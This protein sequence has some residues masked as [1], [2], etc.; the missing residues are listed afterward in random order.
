MRGMEAS[1]A[2]PAGRVGFFRSLWRAVRAVFH[3]TT[4]TLFFL[5]A[6]S[7]LSATVRMWRQGGA[8]HW[9][10]VVCGIFIGMMIV[11]GLTSFRAA[12]RVR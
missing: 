7:W 6:I 9:V 4:G 1:A 2:R 8:A 5:M 10:F 3:E 11:F 12:R